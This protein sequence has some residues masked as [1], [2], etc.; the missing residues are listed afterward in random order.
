M[1]RFCV[2]V[3]A[4]DR[5]L[6]H[7]WF[8]GTQRPNWDLFVAYYGDSEEEFARLKAVSRRIFRVKGGKFQNVRQ[9]LAIEPDLFRAYRYV[10]IC[11]D[12]LIMACD[13]INAMFD[14]AER[15]GFWVCQPAFSALG[16]ISLDVTR[17]LVPGSVRIVNFVE[18]TA[19]LFER[20]RLDEFM[21]V[22]DGTLVGWGIDFWFSNV[23]RARD[24]GRFAVIDSVVVT[25][26]LDVDKP[27][28]DRE[29]DR[30]QSRDLRQA[31]W[32][33]VKDARGIEQYPPKTVGI[34]ET[35]EGSHVASQGPRGRGSRPA[36]AHTMNPFAAEA[37]QWAACGADLAMLDTLQLFFVGGAPRS[38]TTWLQQMLDCH[39]EVSCRGEGLLRK[40]LAEPITKMFADW[41]AALDEKNRKIFSHSGGY[42]LPSDE[43]AEYLAR[44]A[45]LLALRQQAPS[46]DCRAIGEKTP[47]NVF[48]FPKLERLFPN[49]KLINIARD[50]RDV[51]TSAWHFFHKLKPGQDEVAAKMDF[52]RGALPSIG[53]GARVAI[54]L[55]Q[56]RPDHVTTVT[57]DA[58]RG[59]PAPVLAGLFRFLGVPDRADIV[60]SCIEQTAFSRQ[61][62]GREAGQEQS[63]AFFRK[64]V[65]GDWRSTLTPEMNDLILREVGWIFAYYGWPI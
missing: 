48:F 60:A 40:Y 53:E 16:K 13:Q 37:A 25:N 28:G 45:I 9:W 65:V 12:D 33:A 31:Q 26:A 30:L 55:Q 47:E 49:A 19:P 6:V 18:I 24:S 21:N 46:A 56:R 44:T 1:P 61:T 11:D 34:L 23:L 43:A 35:L 52:I 51:L 27:G 42:P 22:Y 5:N 7:W 64:G 15:H 8:S 2:F 57:Y 59:D 32:H 58:L 41:R 4:G 20:D 3:S 63:G 36:S 10:W 54:A 17:Q 38:G 50:P 62:G 29:I 39:P 14:L